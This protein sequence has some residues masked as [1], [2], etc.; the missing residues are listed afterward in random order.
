MTHITCAF[1]NTFGQDTNYYA[2]IPDHTQPQGELRGSNTSG[3]SLQIRSEYPV[4][5]QDTNL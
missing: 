4:Y 3:M 1:T 5:M 2:S